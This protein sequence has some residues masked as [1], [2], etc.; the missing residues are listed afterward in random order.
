MGGRE[1]GRN[2]NSG[3][4][5]EGGLRVVRT[6]ASTKIPIQAWMMEMMIQTRYNDGDNDPSKIYIQQ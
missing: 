1:G 4:D 2:E 3:L 5:D 6:T